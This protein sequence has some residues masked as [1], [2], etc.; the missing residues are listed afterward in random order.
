[1]AALKLSGAQ[2]ST[3]PTASFPLFPPTGM[4]MLRA[5]LCWVQM[6]LGDM[7]QERQAEAP[8]VLGDGPAR[9][10][11]SQLP[12]FC[13]TCMADGGAEEAVCP[14]TSHDLGL[15][16]VLGKGKASPGAHRDPPHTEICLRRWLPGWASGSPRPWGLP[17]LGRLPLTP[18]SE[19]T[20]CFT[21]NLDL[22]LWTHAFGF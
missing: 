5:P 17:P 12:G 7:M 1:M 10:S 2:V 3:A 8:G 9:V 16:R 6:S 18:Q 22:D 15:P 21:L 20:V 19:S 11:P 4:G 13:R 14:A